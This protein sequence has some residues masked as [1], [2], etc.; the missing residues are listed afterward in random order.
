[1]VNGARLSIHGCGRIV[2]EPQIRESGSYTF[3]AVKLAQWPEEAAKGTADR[4]QLLMGLELSLKKDQP[5]PRRGDII[6]IESGNYSVGTKTRE[7]GSQ[8]TYHNVV[9]WVWRTLASTKASEPS[10]KPT[11]EGNLATPD[12][13]S[14]ATPPP[15]P[16]TI[17]DEDEE[18]PF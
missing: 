7:D 18:V 17:R 2:E 16:P 5:P 15:P 4:K 12:R 8:A 1:M 9:A 10:P 6:L 13:P 14:M 3:A 11:G